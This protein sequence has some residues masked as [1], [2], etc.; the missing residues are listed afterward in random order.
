MMIAFVLFLTPV[1]FGAV[2]EVRRPHLTELFECKRSNC[3]DG[4]Q[5][6]IAHQ[7]VVPCNWYRVERLGAVSFHSFRSTNS[8]II[9]AR[10]P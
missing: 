1:Q 9:S 2:H 10:A 3:L 8:R 7:I 4:V 6:Q 5:V